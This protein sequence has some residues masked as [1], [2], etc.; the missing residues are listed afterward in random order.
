MHTLTVLTPHDFTLY[1][2]D[3]VILHIPTAGKMCRLEERRA[4]PSTTTVD[5]VLVPRTELGYAEPVVI[6]PDGSREPVP[7]PT[8]GVLLL[9]S[10]VTA[11]ELADRDD[12]VF[13]LDEV[14]DAHNRIIGCRGL[15]SFT[16]RPTEEES[17]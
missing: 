16:E 1:D 10:R 8:P 11:Q 6:N 9:V 13:P 15:G 17:A 7:P 2:G 4:A 5:G 14:R 12:V 3:T